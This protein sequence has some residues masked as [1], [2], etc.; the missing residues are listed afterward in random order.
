M[1]LDNISLS[2]YPDKPVVKICDFETSF[3][4]P[5]AEGGRG[6]AGPFLQY[7]GPEFTCNDRV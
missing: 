5:T 4:A 7:L 2:H 1:Q 3:S 6:F